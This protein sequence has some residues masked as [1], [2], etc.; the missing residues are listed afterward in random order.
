M[1]T[2]QPSGAPAAIN[3][4]LNNQ[5][6]TK[7]GNNDLLPSTGEGS[8]NSVMGANNT[9]PLGAGNNFEK[10]LNSEIKKES[11]SNKEPIPAAAGNNPAKLV[12]GI[13]S[14]IKTSEQM[15][16]ANQPASTGQQPGILDKITNFAKNAANNILPSKNVCFVPNS[17]WSIMEAGNILPYTSVPVLAVKLFA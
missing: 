5:T 13:N 7:P 2:N 10:A 4:P 9:A 3:K 1:A 14:R 6:T 11:A 16:A 17:Y 15:L 8:L 12:Q